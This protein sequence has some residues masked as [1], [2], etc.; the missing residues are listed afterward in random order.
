MAE[1]FLIMNEAGRYLT[2]ALDW[3]THTGDTAMWLVD[4]SSKLTNAVEGNVLETSADVD[5]NGAAFNLDGIDGGLNLQRGPSRLPSAHLAELRSKGFTVLDNLIDAAA[6]ER[7]KSDAAKELA[8]QSPDAETFDVRLGVANGISWSTD[9]ARAVT[10]PVALWLIQTYLGNEEIHFCHPPGV[11][12][13]RPAK[14]LIGT[15][16]DIGWHSDYPYHPGILERARWADEQPLAVQFN[17]CVDAFRQDNGATQY[18]PDSHQKRT[19]PPMEFN[20]GGTRMGKG[21]HKDVKQMVAPSGSALVYDARVW[22]RACEELNVSGNDR[23]AIL[24][25]VALSWVRPMGDKSASAETYR[26]S[27]TP[28]QLTERERSDIERLCLQ[29]TSDA[30]TGAPLIVSREV[31]MRK[32]A[33][34]QHD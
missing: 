26:Q 15:H 27:A 6:V 1:Y 20:E 13:M 30:P 21:V 24:N 34:A 12:V 16:P 5:T 7:I 10:N 8:A 28:R 23:Y 31:A 11:T 9:V 14:E 33:E 17:V 2:A 22:H 19:F 25:A 32:R 4:T 18:L 3:V 29:E